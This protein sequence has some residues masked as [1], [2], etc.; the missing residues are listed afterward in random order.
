V[1]VNLLSRPISVTKRV[2]KELFRY[3]TQSGPKGAPGAAD[4]ALPVGSVAREDVI[5]DCNVQPK[6]LKEQPFLVLLSDTWDL[7]LG[8]T[9][10]R[11]NSRVKNSQ[12]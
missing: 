2:V 5:E 3:F 6:T 12:L 4:A 9:T 8:I 11:Q 1:Y 10:N 7:L